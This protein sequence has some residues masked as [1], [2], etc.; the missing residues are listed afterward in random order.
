MA[1]HEYKIRPDGTASCPPAW[2]AGVDGTVYSRRTDE[3]FGDVTY[4][5]ENAPF[6]AGFLESSA[7]AIVYLDF[8]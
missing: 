5:R 8:S 7:G 2:L 1:I 4:E 3:T 6:I